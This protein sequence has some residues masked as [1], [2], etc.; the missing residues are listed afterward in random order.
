MFAALLSLA[1]VAAEG[2]ETSKVPFYV[3]GGLAAGWAI[4]LF[5][6]GMRS[7]DFPVSDGAKRGVITVSVV[8]VA[9]AMAS[10][11]LTG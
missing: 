7:P 6:V 4:L 3:L 2:E 5:L 11:V 9:A 10:A 8:L 1:T